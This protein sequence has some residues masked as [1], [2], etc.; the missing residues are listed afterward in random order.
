MNMKYILRATFRVVVRIKGDCAFLPQLPRV[1]FGGVKELNHSLIGNR[2]I[3]GFSN[4]L[5]CC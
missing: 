5:W 2:R 3:R 1:S 4:V